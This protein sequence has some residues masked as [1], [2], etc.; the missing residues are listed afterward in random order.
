MLVYGGM[1]RG[2]L[3]TSTAVSWEGHFSGLTVGIALAW[4]TSKLQKTTV[5][6][7]SQRSQL[8]S[9]SDQ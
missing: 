6:K 7:A 4:F 2:I 8:Y 3:P 9:L 5:A 1:L